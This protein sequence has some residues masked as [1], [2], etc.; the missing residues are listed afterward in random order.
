MNIN[1]KFKVGDNVFIVRNNEIKKMQVKTINISVTDRGSKPVAIT[2][3]VGKL[4]TEMIESQLGATPQ[5]AANALIEKYRKRHPEDFEENPENPTERNVRNRT[6]ALEIED[7][8][9]EFDEIINQHL[10]EQE[11]DDDDEEEDEDD[12]DY[13]YER[14]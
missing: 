5:E 10:E 11:E 14:Y 7:S 2:Y 6:S 13:E 9:D 4:Q 12:D 8:I 1:T 3:M